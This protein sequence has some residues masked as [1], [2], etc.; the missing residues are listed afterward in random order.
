MPLH[1][2]IILISL[3]FATSAVSL[4]CSKHSGQYLTSGRSYR[5]GFAASAPKPELSSILQSLS[6]WTVHADAAIISNEPPWDSLLDGK[7]IPS[8]VRNNYSSLMQLYR[9]AGLKVWIYLDP[10]NGLDRT[11]DSRALAN[12]GKSIAQQ[13]VQLLFVAFACAMDSIL[14]PDHLGL[15]LE[16]NLIRL[17]APS[18]IYDGVKSAVN[19]AASAIR[20]FDKQT[21]LSC[22]VQAD[23]AWGLLG[24]QAGYAGIDKDFS[25]FQFLNELGI[26]T[27][28][29]MVFKSPSDMPAN[30]FSRL[31]NGKAMPVFVSE[32]GWVSG[33]IPSLSI[34][35]ST[36]QQ[37]GYVSRMHELL[38]NAHASAWFQLAFTD[39]ALSAWSPADS[40]GLY[41]FAT[42]GMVD[43]NFIAKPA[44]ATWD[45]LR[46]LHL[47]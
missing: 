38:Q 34:N 15:A 14:H 25:D 32:S 21:P 37:K 40:A 26:S 3:I 16:T 39:I 33:S 2:R 28:P 5:M 18:S 42:L 19:A 8:L 17:A 4:N 30:Y 47:N 24:A 6:I 29:Y 13:D 36:L 46:S 9:N 45:S 31:L 43:T 27:Y 11:H 12:R 10:E 1:Y 7:D 23:V 44:F 22:S 35:S 20:Q 41:P